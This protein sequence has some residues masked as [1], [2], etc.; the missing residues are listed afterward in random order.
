MALGSDYHTKTL[1]T[2]LIE[3]K[4]D[5]RTL[6]LIIAKVTILSFQR[7]GPITNMTIGEYL[8]GEQCDNSYVVE[9][10]RHKSRRRRGPAKMQFD[11]DDK[12]VV[13]IY[14]RGIMFVT[15]IFVIFHRYAEL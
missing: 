3:N 8:R 11:D 2:V 7:P 9:V 15:L 14:Y 1:K 5:I 6:S 12:K 4:W 13:N 10:S